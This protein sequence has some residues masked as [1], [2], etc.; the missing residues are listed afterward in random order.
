MVLYIYT[1]NERFN[2]SY[3][4]AA[5]TINTN[6]SGRKYTLSNNLK[7][8]MHPNN[9]MHSSSGLQSL[10]TIMT[11]FVLMNAENSYM[12]NKL[13]LYTHVLVMNTHMNTAFS[14]SSLQEM[15]P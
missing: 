15:G 4:M 1:R 3:T 10:H 2:V 5:N 9:N 13:V 11:I 8:I 12:E 7:E 6:K 14:S